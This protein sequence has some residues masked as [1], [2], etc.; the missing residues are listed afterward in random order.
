MQER[1]RVVPRPPKGASITLAQAKK[2]WL[3]VERESAAKSVSR[4]ATRTQSVKKDTAAPA[5]AKPAKSASS[6]KKK[7]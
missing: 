2:A 1:L 5:E 7:Q 3:K 4:A 6:A